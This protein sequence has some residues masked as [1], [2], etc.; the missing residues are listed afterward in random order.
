MKKAHSTRI[1]PY[2]LNSVAE[3]RDQISSMRHPVKE[4][5]RP[6]ELGSPQRIAGNK[7]DPPKK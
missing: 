1:N 2:D 6:Y 3:R 7:N 4:P 5:P